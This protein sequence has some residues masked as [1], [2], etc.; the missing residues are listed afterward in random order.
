MDKHQTVREQILAA[1]KAQKARRSK[2]VSARDEYDRE[3]REH[4]K[5]H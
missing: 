2:Q 3:L 1:I 4:N 5:D